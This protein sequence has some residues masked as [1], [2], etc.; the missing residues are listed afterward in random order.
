MRNV[1]LFL[2]LVATC[3]CVPGSFVYHE[4]TAPGGFL[5]HSPG[6]SLAPKDRI[7]F[8]AS[9]IKIQLK[10][11]QAGLL[12]DL[13]IPDQM[14][15]SL[16]TANIQL[17]EN[18]SRDRKIFQIED[19][20]YFDFKESRYI[21]LGPTDVLMGSTRQHALGSEPRQ[22]HIFVP[23]D[24]PEKRHYFVQLPLIRI[25]ESNTEF[26]PIEFRSKQGFGVGPVNY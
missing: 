5:V 25:G 16:V 21:K 17:Y 4:P 24:G 22:F 8:Q 1:M 15:A 12:I 13:F 11:N 14:S 6:L 3:G 10:G 19:I 20:M 7:E 9:G 23:L 18:D 2:L 26:P